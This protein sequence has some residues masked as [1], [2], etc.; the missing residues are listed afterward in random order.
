[1]AEWL[2]KNADG[3]AKEASTSKDVSSPIGRSVGRSVTYFSVI[4]LQY[5][6]GQHDAT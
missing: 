6:S 2:E 3:A 5:S 4:E 1:L